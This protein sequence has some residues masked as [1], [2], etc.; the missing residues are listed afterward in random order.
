MAISKINR[1]RDTNENIG[2]RNVV[3][4]HATN[5]MKLQEEIYNRVKTGHVTNKND[6]QMRK[7]Q[8]NMKLFHGST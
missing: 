1:H 2:Y 6:Q 8:S 7:A 4:E 5:T 3:W